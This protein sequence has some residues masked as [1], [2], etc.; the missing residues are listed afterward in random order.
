LKK[1]SIV[2]AVKRFEGFVDQ[3][4][5]DDLGGIELPVRLG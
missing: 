5:H 2:D 3:G 4:F 1:T